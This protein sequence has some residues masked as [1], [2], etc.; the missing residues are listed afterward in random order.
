MNY[1]KSGIG[2]GSESFKY[3]GIGN[4]KP[5][6]VN[7]TRDALSTFLNRT[8][9]KDPVYITE[10]QE[11]GK[12]IKTV[13]LDIWGEMQEGADNPAFKTKVTFFLKGKYDISRNGSTK[14]IN[15]Q[16]IASYIPEGKSLEDLNKNK[17]WYHIDSARKALGGEDL[18]VTFFSKLL[19]VETRLDQFTLKDG[20]VPDFFLDTESLFKNDFSSIQEV[21]ND[22]TT[23]TIKCYVGI[24]TREKDDKTYY[25]MEIYNKQFGFG[26]AKSNAAII[27][28]LNNEYLTFKNNIAPISETLVPFV[29]NEIKANNTTS[30]GS[31]EFSNAGISD[32]LPF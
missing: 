25:D 29:P 28:A 24:K 10:M 16:G 6:I 1:K 31:S 12:S 5:I 3:Y 30:E 21:I 23:K 8:I 22:P 18:I 15:G 26:G 20:D 14:Y 9:T 11:D 7:P 13:R 27:D 17:V 32:D 4:F 2:S 19:N